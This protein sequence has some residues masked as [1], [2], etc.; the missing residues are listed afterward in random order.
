MGFLTGAGIFIV[1]NNNN[2]LVAILFGNKGHEYSELG[3]VIDPGETPEETASREAKEESA[4]LIQIKPH[5]LKQISIPI[6]HHKYMSYIIYIN[7]ISAR[8]YYHNVK[9]VF[10]KCKPHVWK[11]NSSMVRIDLQNLI[12]NSM[13]NKNIM[14]DIDGNLIRVRDRTIGIVKKAINTFSNLK[15]PITLHQNVTFTSRMSCLI[16]TYTYT[17]QQ[18]IPQIQQLQNKTKSYAIYAVPNF[19]NKDK[20]LHNC[21][22]KWG[23][24]HV[25]LAGFS[26]LHPQIKPFLQMLSRV[27][28]KIWHINTNNIRIKNNT[29]Y[30]N[31]RTL[32]K[33]ANALANNGF[34]KI[35]GKKFSGVDWHITFEDCKIPPNI[36]NILAF[37]SWSFIIV[38]DNNDGTYSWLEKYTITII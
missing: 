9:L 3:G 16:G 35:K 25:T 19:K 11:E 20:H 14:K 13:A 36:M 28:R 34:N 26:P 23:G 1:E 7:K 29:I 10:G 6:L 2:N 31:S 38:R 5:E 8:D 30:F 18:N 32:D 15:N 22:I 37:V 17:I 33:V 27:G 24:L 4:N 12:Q 21:N